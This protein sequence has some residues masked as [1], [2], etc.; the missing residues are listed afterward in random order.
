MADQRNVPVPPPL[1]AWAKRLTPAER[2]AERDYSSARTDAEGSN[3]WLRALAEI[4]LDGKRDPNNRDD[5]LPDRWWNPLLPTSIP[6]C[7]IC[8]LPNRKGL[9]KGCATLEDYFEWPFAS[10]EFLCVADKREHPEHLIWS[11]KDCSTNWPGDVGNGWLSG[12]GTALSAY[13]EAYRH[14]LIPEGAVVTSIPSRAPAIATAMQSAADRG[15][16]AV[17]PEVTGTKNGDWLQHKSASQDERLA[18]TSSDWRVDDEIVRG[19]DVLLLDDVWVTG[20]TVCSYATALHDAGAAKV[21]CLSV[22][23]HLDSRNVDYAD[24]LGILRRQ[25]EWRWSVEGTRSSQPTR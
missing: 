19:R 23:R 2:Q 16:Y 15:W 12:V 7:E 13:L 22:V 18:R 9:C 1:K 20:A 14:R 8:T 24:A 17:Q 21:R 4:E 10:V 5:W 11:W 25:T 3:S 6:R